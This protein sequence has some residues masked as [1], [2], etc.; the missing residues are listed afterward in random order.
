MAKEEL[1]KTV[2]TPDNVAN[3]EQ[4]SGIKLSPDAKQLLYHVKPAYKTS[5]H[6][7][8]SIWLGDVG[9]ADSARQFTSGIFND[10]SARFHPDGKR[11]IFLSDRHKAGGPAQIYSISLSGGEASPL[12][13]KDNKCAVSEFEISSDGKYIAFL[14][15]D[16][17]TPEDER[18]EKE[19]DDPQVFSDK[20]KFNHLR[21]YNFA[22]RDVRGLKATN[23]NHV[24]QLVW[25]PD[26]KSIFFLTRA[27][28]A[29]EFSSEKT[30]LQ[31]ISVVVDTQPEVIGSYP[32]SPYGLCALH[33]GRIIDI[34]TH[35]LMRLSDSKSVYIRNVQNFNESKRLYGETNCAVR[36]VDLR[37]DGL[38][39]VEIAEGL[40]IVILSFDTMAHN[41]S[42][43]YSTKDE[44]IERGSWD[45]RKQEDGAFILAVIKSSA[46]RQE[47]PNVWTGTRSSSDGLVKLDTKISSHLKWT[48]EVP[49]MHTE[50][51]F[52]DAK[53]GTKLDGVIMFPPSN[54]QP[55]PPRA[56]P[57]IMLVHGGPY[58]R[59]TLGYV[60]TFYNW[61]F[62]LAAQG[63]LVILPNYRGG[64]G[65][66]FEFA[67]AAHGGMG[68]LDWSDCESMLDAAIERGLADPNRLGIGGWSQGGFMTA[69]GVAT[70]K[71]RFKAG[72][73]GAGVSDWG[74][75][76]ASSDL[77][78][79]EADLGGCAPWDTADPNQRIDLRGN[80]IGRVAG[81][82]T[83]VLILHGE[84][85]ERVPVT[86]GIEF[87]R[88]LRRKA[89]Y[90]DRAQL[91]I[92]PREPHSF[93]EKNHAK[94][95]M[96]RVIEH[97]GDWL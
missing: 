34:Q 41:G 92:Y 90:P 75:L 65:H 81:V 46:V 89:K 49:I 24:F 37:S 58:W 63:F 19:K 40:D 27:H 61:Q 50:P 71:N 74:A 29:L 85:D 93:V 11:I 42:T 59:S 47:P 7:T 3:S 43:V 33:D 5:E 60:P 21:L 83:A 96:K 80:P 97:F 67:R 44:D 20:R 16:E 12:F 18:R 38:I 94:D 84:K 32:H 62:L 70:T 45:A 13:G 35:D 87:F 76:M 53:D 15:A 28:S 10:H 68:T 79:F 6:D 22:T 82:E 54:K 86:Q 9:S 55:N 95:V 30:D 78:G 25:A 66:G 88:G 8:C 2:F 48:T 56:L 69:W 64:Q 23:G 31:R 77:P 14:S 51:F 26:S 91:V 73:M 1:T 52:W 4:L 36:I 57:T 72:V 39:A 17:P